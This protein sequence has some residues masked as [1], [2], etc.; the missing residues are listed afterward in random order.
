MPGKEDKLTIAAST[1]TNLAGYGTS[2]FSSTVGSHKTFKLDKPLG[3]G[4]NKRIINTVNGGS[5]GVRTI[6]VGSTKV[7]FV[8]NSTKIYHKLH[9][10]ANSKGGSID[11]LASSTYKYFVIRNT[12]SVSFS[13]SITTT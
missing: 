9:F 4:I 7:S 8:N 6:L 10:S 13:T 1:G 12:T 11:L 5:S 3:V 2:V